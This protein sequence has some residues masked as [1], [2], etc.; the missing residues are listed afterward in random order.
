MNWKD[1]DAFAVLKPLLKPALR[2]QLVVDRGEVAVARYGGVPAGIEGEAWPACQACQTPLAFFAQ[3]PAH[4]RLYRFF[5]CTACREGSANRLSHA[6]ALLA[7][8]DDSPFVTHPGSPALKSPLVPHEWVLEEVVT[9]PMEEELDLLPPELET[10]ALELA[11]WGELDETAYREGAKALASHG[12]DME[13][14]TRIGGYANTIQDPVIAV[15]PTCAESMPFLAR[16][17]SHEETGWEWGDE[18]MLFL[19]ACPEHPEHY[20]AEVQSY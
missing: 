9:I 11:A 10:P 2:A 5:Y 13:N 8:P 15:C 18:G 6:S 4:G 12:V 20:H 1:P 19:Y 14:S 7:L 16:L 17:A 3:F